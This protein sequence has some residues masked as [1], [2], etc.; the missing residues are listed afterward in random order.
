MAGIYLH[1]PFCSRKCAYCDFYSEADRNDLVSEFLRSMK[2]EIGLRSDFFSEG[3]TIDTVY[4][5]GGTPSLIPP[6]HIE[7]L[8]DK[9]RTR[10]AISDHAEITIEVNPG[11]VGVDHFKAYRTAGIN[12]L[13]IGVQSL[14]DAELRLL[15][16]M[17]ASADAL[18]TIADARAC[19]FE[20]IGIDFIFGLPGQTVARWRRTL[21]KSL[22]LHP[23]H[24]SAYSLTW[25]ETTP[26]GRKIE[27]GRLPKPQEETI[28]AMYL[29]THDLLAD[30]GYD[31]YEISNYAHP[32]RR[33]RHNEGYWTG[34]PYV[35]LGPSAHSFQHRQRSWNVSDVQ[36]YIDVLSQNQIP[37]AGKEILGTDQIAIERIILGLRR[38]EGL[39]LS[40]FG[41]RQESLNPL[42]QKGLGRIVD[43]CFRLTETGFLLADEIALELVA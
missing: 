2:R 9:I 26:L 6:H 23:E 4:L 16:R 15:G 7:R 8:L 42:I 41:K 5:G 1:I 13:S 39:S 29:L 11:T 27:T 43:N 35:G 40:Q 25:N 38:R 31:H 37:V 24:I 12:R 34:E 30:A 36:T 20:N 14:A 21:R 33:C 3:T 32:G 22:S 28:A 19:G 17:H 10:F 18:K